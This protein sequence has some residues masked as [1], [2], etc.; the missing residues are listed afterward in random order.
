M[1]R[2]SRLI[3]PVLGRGVTPQGT[4]AERRWV[5]AGS[6]AVGTGGPCRTVSAWQAKILT[7]RWQFTVRRGSTAPTTMGSNTSAIPIR[8]GSTNSADI[9]GWRP[10]CFPV[11]NP[12]HRCVYLGHPGAVCRRSAALGWL[13]PVGGG[14]TR[15]AG[16]AAGI[17]AGVAGTAVGTTAGAAGMVVG[18]GR[19]GGGRRGVGTVWGWW[20]AWPS[21]TCRFWPDPAPE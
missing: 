20:E 17:T 11:G 2:V 7:F 13:R 18:A 16:M 4:W 12:A 5:A 6:V 9:T 1:D 14:V 10:R 8:L 19:V 3:P 15:G 21:K